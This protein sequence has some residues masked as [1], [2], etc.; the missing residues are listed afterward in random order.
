MLIL[1][2]RVDE[3]ICIGD[4]IRVTILGIRGNQ[5]RL[6]VDAPKEV[7]VHREEVYQRIQHGKLPPIPDIPAVPPVPAAP[8]VPP[9]PEVPE[10]QDFQ[11]RSA[12]SR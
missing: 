9:V 5:I 1:S 6:G 8:P 10:I 12:C 7:K 11:P 4:D 3:T 2:R